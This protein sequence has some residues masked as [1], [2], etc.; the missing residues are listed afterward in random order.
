M[1]LPALCQDVIAPPKA[2]NSAL[3]LIKYL[4]VLCGTVLTNRNGIFSVVSDCQ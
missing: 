1:N 4:G 2:A 3:A